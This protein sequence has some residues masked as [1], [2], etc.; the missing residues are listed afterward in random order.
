MREKTAGKNLRDELWERT[1]TMNCRDELQG[2][3]AERNCKERS[4]WEGLQGNERGKEL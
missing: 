1:V 3:I 2:R 4:Y